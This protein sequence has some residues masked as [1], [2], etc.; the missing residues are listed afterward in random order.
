MN[1]NT[2]INLHVLYVIVCLFCK[3]DD[4]NSQLSQNV[5]ADTGIVNTYL[6]T[7]SLV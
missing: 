4:I 2:N 7:F 6:Y 3:F 5:V 1:I